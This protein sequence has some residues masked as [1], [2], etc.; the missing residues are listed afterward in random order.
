MTPIG[1]IVW[2]PQRG[3][4]EPQKAKPFRVYASK[5][6]ALKMAMDWGGDRESL[7]V[8]QVFAVAQ[9]IEAQRAET[10]NTGSVADESAVA[11]PCAQSDTAINAATGGQQ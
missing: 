11:K 5:S 8:R 7:D 6:T 9:A 3:P 4:Y 2:H 10:E 1:W